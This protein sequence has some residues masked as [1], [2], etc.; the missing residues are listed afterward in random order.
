MQAS[1]DQIRQLIISRRSCKPS[2][3]NGKIIPENQIM[4]M[5]E[6]GDWAPNHGRTEPWRFFVYG[7]SILEKFC[8]DHAE[9]YHQH[10]QP[11]NFNPAKYQSLKNQFTS[12]SHII[13]VAMKR[14]QPTGIPMLEEYAATAAAI[15]NILLGAEALGIS[16]L[17]STGGMTHHPALKSYAGLSESDEILAL[18]HLGYSDTAPAQGIRKIPLAEKII[19]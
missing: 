16:T 19:R 9:L 2:S 3:M 10:T 12:V 18:L 14:T 4:A 15:Q 6:L 8:A 11:E 7:G 13:L 17:W 1:F 5:L